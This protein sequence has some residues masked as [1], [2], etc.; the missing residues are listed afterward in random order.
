MCVCVFAHTWADVCVLG[1]VSGFVCVCDG[2]C[3]CVR[4]YAC[5]CA[6]FLLCT[7]ESVSK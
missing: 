2:V 4:V 3:V 7:T 6:L 5:V 1:N